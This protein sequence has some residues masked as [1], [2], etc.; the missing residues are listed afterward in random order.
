MRIE[1]YVGLSYEPLEKTIEKKMVTDFGYQ[2]T[3][4]DK[5]IEGSTPELMHLAADDDPS[6]WFNLHPY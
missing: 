2:L 5:F 1:R 6:H 3:E 4:L